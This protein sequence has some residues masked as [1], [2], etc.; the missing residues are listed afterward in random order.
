MKEK[1]EKKKK[2]NKKKT[3][4]NGKYESYLKNW[5]GNISTS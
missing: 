2:K 1:D 3:E 4:E 5:K